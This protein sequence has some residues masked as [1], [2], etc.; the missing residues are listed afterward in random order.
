[1]VVRVGMVVGMP[2]PVWVDRLEPSCCGGSG[3][4]AVVADIWAGVG[5]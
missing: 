4:G 2:V 3:L 5:C 1:M